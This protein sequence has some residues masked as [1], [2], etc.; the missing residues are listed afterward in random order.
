MSQSTNIS[1][2]TN[3]SNKNRNIL[4]TREKTPS[5]RFHPCTTITEM[6]QSKEFLIAPNTIDR[7]NFKHN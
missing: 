2:L 7:A 5:F 6:V 4:H 3:R 1:S